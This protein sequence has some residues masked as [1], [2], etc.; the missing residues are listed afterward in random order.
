[1]VEGIIAKVQKS[2]MEAGTM[3]F[4]ALFQRELA[5]LS[6]P[7]STSGGGGGAGGGS[8]DSNSRLLSDG[9][10]G[11][12]PGARKKIRGFLKPYFNK[13]DDDKSGDMDVHEVRQLLK[14]LG[15]VVS[16]TGVCHRHRHCH[17]HY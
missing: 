5:S 16:V 8:S 7:A 2:E 15:E 4:T 14:D 9:A 1:M 17:C 11:D 3:N 13:Y 10:G 6:Q 12:S